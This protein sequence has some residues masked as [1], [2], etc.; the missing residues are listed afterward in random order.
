L[1]YL[2]AQEVS[3]ANALI[4]SKETKKKRP[5]LIIEAYHKS[6]DLYNFPLLISELFPQYKK[7]FVKTALV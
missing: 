4:R 3:E 5:K 6:S 7:F 2:G 1:T